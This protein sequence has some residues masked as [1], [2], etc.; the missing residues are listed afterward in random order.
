MANSVSSTL[1]LSEVFGNL[2]AYFLHASTAGLNHIAIAF[3]RA[4]PHHINYYL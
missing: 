1:G 2:F 3:I 4:R